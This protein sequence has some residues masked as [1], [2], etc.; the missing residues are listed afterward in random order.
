MIKHLYGYRKKNNGKNFKS[1]GK[2]KVKGKIIK[3]FMIKEAKFSFLA[4]EEEEEWRAGADIT[5]AHG[6][7][8]RYLGITYKQ[9]IGQ[10]EEWGKLEAEEQKREAEEKK[11][12]SE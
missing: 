7:Q 5:I 10:S 6:K 12:K 2:Y 11:R 8:I 3:T 4:G 9:I 1:S